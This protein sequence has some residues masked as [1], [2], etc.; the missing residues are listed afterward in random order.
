MGRYP[1]IAKFYEVTYTRCSKNT[2]YMSDLAWHIR[3]PEDID[4]DSGV[5]FL[6]TNVT[7]LD[8]KTNVQML[9]YSSD[10]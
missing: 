10:C 8:E 2:K 1:S 3:Q 9:I 7:E 5:Y 4:R 6:R